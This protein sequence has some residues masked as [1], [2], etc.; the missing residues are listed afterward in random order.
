MSTEKPDQIKTLKELQIKPEWR[1][2]W[3]EWEGWKFLYKEPSAPIARKARSMARI[4]HPSIP[5]FTADIDM[6]SHI[7]LP[8][9]TIKA[10]TPEKKELELSSEEW[11]VFYDGKEGTKSQSAID[12]VIPDVAVRIL[13][14]QFMALMMTT[15]EHDDFLRRSQEEKTLKGGS[16]TANSAD[17]VEH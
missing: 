8:A 14:Q 10:I 16:P 15:E 17:S 4:W 12:P 2:K 3:A 9:C 11:K 1:T 7:L 13:S 6:I 5:E